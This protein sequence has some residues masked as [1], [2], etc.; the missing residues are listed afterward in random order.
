MDFNRFNTN[1]RSFKIMKNMTSKTKKIENSENDNFFS[2]SVPKNVPYKACQ[3]L[4]IPLNGLNIQ[5]D[6]IR[7]SGPRFKVPQKKVVDT[8]RLEFCTIRK[9]RIVQRSTSLSTSKNYI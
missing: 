6:L 5:Q 3:I 1:R 4:H 2:V 8:E 9:P 7:G